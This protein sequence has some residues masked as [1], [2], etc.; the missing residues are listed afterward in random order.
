MCGEGIGDL[1]TILKSTGSSAFSEENSSESVSDSVSSKW[2]RMADGGPVAGYKQTDASPPPPVVSLKRT[3]FRL[4]EERT[5][6]PRTLAGVGADSES[7][8]VIQHLRDD[9]RGLSAGERI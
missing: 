8:L 2:K 4:D 7:M 5:A 1:S 6:F 3:L 9:F